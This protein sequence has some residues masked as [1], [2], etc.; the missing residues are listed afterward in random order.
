M[1]NAHSKRRSEHGVADVDEQYFTIAEVA[2]FLRVSRWSVRRYIDRGELHA[3]KAPGR[4][5]AI[6]IPKPSYTE[7]IRA[8]T[9][10]ASKEP[11]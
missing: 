6:R 7:F 1:S 5:G 3:I 9:V 11:R 2:G 8:H 10:T 4:N